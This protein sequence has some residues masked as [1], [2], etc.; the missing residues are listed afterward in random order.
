M[1]ASRGILY[2]SILSVSNFLS[3]SNFFRWK[4]KQPD[5]DFFSELTSPFMKCKYFHSRLYCVCGYLLKTVAIVTDNK[6]PKM[7]PTWALPNQERLSV[8]SEVGRSSWN[9]PL[10]GLILLAQVR[11]ASGSQDCS[12]PTPLCRESRVCQGSRKYDSAMW[13]VIQ[14][15]PKYKYSKLY[16]TVRE[17]TRRQTSLDPLREGG[18]VIFCLDSASRALPHVQ[19]RVKT[20]ALH[21]EGA[22]SSTGYKYKYDKH[23][24]L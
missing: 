19:V 20:G 10:V 6:T 15:N 5:W 22:R 12:R 18:S 4:K 23:E 21:R 8:G 24:L 17:P 9:S 7:Q 13:F 2:V 14:Y 1:S 16:S 3:M 11:L